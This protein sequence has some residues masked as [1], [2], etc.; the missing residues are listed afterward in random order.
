MYLRTPSTWLGG[1][2]PKKLFDTGGEYVA[3][4][5]SAK[6][7]AVLAGDS[8]YQPYIKQVLNSPAASALPKNFIRIISSPNDVPDRRL[9]DR[10]VRDGSGK[11]V[12]G[13]IDR[14]KGIIYLL[15]TP[16]IRGY[17]RL[18]LALHETVHLFAHPFMSVIDD[19]TFERR[20]GRPACPSQSDV[21]S[22]QRMY[23][24][25]FGEGAT[26]AITEQ[27][28]ER[29]EISKYYLERPYDEY[30]PPLFEVIRIF[31]VDR[32]A[33][34]YFGGEINE[35]TH[36]M[37]FRWGREWRNVSTLTNVRQKDQAVRTIKS[38]EDAFRRRTGDFPTPSPYI[39]SLV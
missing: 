5:D 12:G 11:I 28:M 19:V 22:F 24:T 17:S 32:F 16:R 37:E 7:L 20:Y 25:G 27:I 15:E 31:G 38:L 3:E 29:Q 6:V 4:K 8:P 23:C 34:A 39:R 30:T 9:R 26:Q 18:E 21:G 35:F 36:A 33:R 10:F 14:A 13:T 1:P 2:G